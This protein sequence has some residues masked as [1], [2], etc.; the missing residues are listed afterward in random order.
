MRLFGLIGKP[1]THSFSKAFFTEKFNREQISDC[2]YQNFEL[3]SIEAL[4]QLIQDYPELCGLNVTIPYKKDVIPYLQHATEVVQH[5][6]A[7]NCIRVQEDGLHGENTDVTGFQ[8]SLESVRKPYQ[9]NALVLGTGG[10]SVAVQYALKKMGITY[11]LV[12]RNPKPGMIIYSQ[13]DRSM[14]R[15]HLLIINTT[16]VGMYPHTEQAPEIPYEYLGATH[17]LFDLVYNPEQTLFLKQGAARG[18]ATCN[19]YRMLVLQAE[20]SWKIWNR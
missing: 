14:M 13:I 11:Q 4:P 8:Q 10:S 16:P 17:L 12:S 15:E 7:C 2:A 6:G 18:A 1:L 3:P 20:E 9:K 5:T 19:G